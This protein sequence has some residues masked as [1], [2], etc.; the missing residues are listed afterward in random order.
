MILSTGIGSIFNFVKFHICEILDDLYSLYLSIGFH[1]T[2][3][4]G[5]I[6]LI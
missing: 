5:L 6:H 3:N 4:K 2:I 1:D